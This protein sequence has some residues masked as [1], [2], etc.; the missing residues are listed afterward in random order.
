MFVGAVEL[1]SKTNV[2][3]LSIAARYAAGRPPA[4][5]APPS[6]PTFPSFVADAK[7]EAAL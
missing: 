2:A 1:P 5:P 3:Y 7:A 6:G 4:P